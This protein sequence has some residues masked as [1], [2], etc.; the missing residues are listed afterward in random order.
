MTTE[1]ENNILKCKLVKF[2]NDENTCNFAVC[3]EN[4]DDC[5]QILSDSETLDIFIQEP[6]IRG[7]SRRY[8]GQH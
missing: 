4:E 8:F 5:W 1:Q 6:I 7:L 2:I 3:G